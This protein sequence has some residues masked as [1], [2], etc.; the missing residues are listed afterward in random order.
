MKEFKFSVIGA[1]ASGTLMAIILKN[2]GFLVNL[3]DKDQAKV[4]ALKKCDVLKATGKTEATAKPDLITGDTVEAITGTDIIMVCTT[5][6]A[7]AEVAEAIAKDV[8]AD[9]IVILNPGHVGGVLNFKTALKNAGCAADPVVCEAADMMFACRTMEIGHTFHSG[10]KAKIKLASIPSENA[11]KVAELLK[12]VF[13]CYVPCESVLITGLSGGSGMLHSIPCVMNMNKIELKQNFDYY[14]EGLT[15]GI[16][17]IIE[18]ADAERIAVTRALGLEIEPLLPHLKN[19]YHLEPD[20]LYD[21]IQ[22]CEPYKG[23]KS[24]MNTNHRFMQED[25]LCDLVP[26]ASLGKMLGIPTPTIDMI[27]ELESI[28]LNKDF[29]KEGRTVEKLG[30]AGKTKEEIFEMVK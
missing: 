25:T 17:R 19:V 8:K 27:I 22:S 4:E 9:Q 23:I 12:D 15:P 13:P 21:A 18:K 6:D 29:V 24:P 10:V 20:N 30:L 5:T 26:T 7:H 14:I 16:C 28:M 2:K 11:A 3:M 1:G